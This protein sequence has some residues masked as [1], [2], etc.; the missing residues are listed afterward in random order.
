M[1]TNFLPASKASI[2]TA[3]DW[4]EPAFNYFGEAYV[5]HKAPIR[6]LAPD[7]GEPEFREAQFGLV[8]FWS[9]D[10]KIARHTYSAR[11]ETVAEKP[12]YRTAW[13][14][15]R[16]A[17]VPMLGFFEPDYETG[18]A[19]RWKIERRDGEPFTVAA[20]WDCW[21]SPTEGDTLLHSFSMLIL[22]ADGHPVMGRFHSPGDE[23]RSLAVIP[24]ARRDAWLRAT[25]QEAAMFIRAMP[26]EEFTAAPAPRPARKGSVSLFQ[27][28]GN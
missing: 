24:E 27:A 1:C 15:R 17:L 23:K 26:S 3:L 13:K 7:T 25:P 28:R 16:Y 2:R 12:S 18:K 11:S 9:K 14:Q 4:P 8:P 20:I 22:N 21:R 10:A 6:I 19:I 5:T